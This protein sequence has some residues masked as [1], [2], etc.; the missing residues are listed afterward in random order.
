VQLQLC[1][2]GNGEMNGE[3][4]SRGTNIPYAFDPTSNSSS[5]T[6][7]SSAT[8]SNGSPTADR[9]IV[10]VDFGTTYSGKT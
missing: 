8:A 5:A 2:S 4:A 7:G 1:S 9:L 3:I 10:G 6:N